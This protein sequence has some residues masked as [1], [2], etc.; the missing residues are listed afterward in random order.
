LRELET[1][2]IVIL[3]K[4]EFM[5]FEQNRDGKP[6][7]ECKTGT[8]RSMMSIDKF[9]ASTKAGSIRYYK[10]DKCGAEITDAGVGVGGEIGASAD[11]KK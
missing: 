9:K 3:L 11:A 7:P 6:C 10:C 1:A 4:S 5:V 2:S 8:L